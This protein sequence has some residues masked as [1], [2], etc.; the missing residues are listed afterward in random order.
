MNCSRELIESIH[1]CLPVDRAAAA[2]EFWNGFVSRPL[3]GRC[4]SCCW[5]DWL[6]DVRNDRLAVP[7]PPLLNAIAGA[8]GLRPGDSV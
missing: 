1:V 6:D 3:A 2:V 5:G 7:T 4:C 8:I